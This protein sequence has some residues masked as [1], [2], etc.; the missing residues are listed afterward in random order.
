V[1][2]AGPEPAQRELVREALRL[3][4]KRRLLFAIHDAAFPDDGQDVDVGR[5]TPCGRGGERL[6]EL[7]ARLGF[8]GLQLGPQG[9][10]SRGN[11]SPY[12]GTAFSRSV[13][14]LALAPLVEDEEWRGLLRREEVEPLRAPGRGGRTTP[15]PAREAI[16]RA[17][18]LAHARLVQLRG[19]GAARGAELDARLARF[20]R[21]QAAWLACPGPGARERARPPG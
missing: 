19:A 9:E 10:T 12:D 13:L 18:G 8:D 6:V 5:G 17:L 15:G 3:L 2:Q 14:S 21:E 1:S 4:G 20:S 11:D 7:V 16:R